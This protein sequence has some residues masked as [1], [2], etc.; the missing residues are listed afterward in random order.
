MRQ[1][2]YKRLNLIL[3]KPLPAAKQVLTQI[4]ESYDTNFRLVIGQSDIETDIDVVTIS[5]G[6]NVIVT[7]KGRYV[8]EILSYPTT[9]TIT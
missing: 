7:L 8:V 9:V 1:F 3:Y 4:N 6:N 5:D 2:N